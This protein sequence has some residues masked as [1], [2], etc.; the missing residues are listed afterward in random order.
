MAT[1]STRDPS[2][3]SDPARAG[4]K[5]PSARADRAPLR[6]TLFGHFRLTGPLGDIDLG[7]R[8]LCGLLAF[9]AC[10]APEP[11]PR[12]RL[13]T[14]FWGSHFDAQAKQNLRQALTRLRRAVGPDALASD[15]EVV[16]LNPAAVLC[17]VGQFEAL[18]REGGRDALSAAADLYRGRLI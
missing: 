8:K 17:D 11:Q 15:G 9:L 1:S 12:D 3:T 16:S 4:G 7:S 5:I 13:M 10:T 18:I 2:L 14:L 6:L